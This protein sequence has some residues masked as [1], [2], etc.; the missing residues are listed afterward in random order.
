MVV[1]DDAAAHALARQW[2]TKEGYVISEA[3]TCDAAWDQIQVHP[4]DVILLDILFENG[5]SGWEFLERLRGDHRTAGIPVVVVSIVAELK[6]GLALGALEVLQKPVSG[7]ELLRAVASLGLSAGAE[8][9]SLLVVDDDPRAVEHVSKRLEQTGMYIT[10]AYGGEEALAALSAGSFGAMILDLMMPDVSGFEVVR[11]VRAN[12]ATAQLPIIVLTA[13]VLDPSERTALEKSV[14]AVLSKGDWDDREFLRVVRAAVNQRQR[15][16][17]PTPGPEHSAPLR[18]PTPKPD[19]TLHVLVIDDDAAAR[20]LLKLYLEDSGFVVTAAAGAKDALAAL[21]G[22][23][24]DLITLD[25][26]FEG[27]GDLFLSEGGGAEHL[28]GIPV[29]VVSS[30]DGPET[31]IGL[32]ARA[33]LRKPIRRHEFLEVVREVL[34]GVEQPRPYVI[35]ADDDPNAVKI[36]SSYFSDEAVDIGCAYGGREALALVA[37]RR[38]DVLI[39]DLMMPDVSGFDVLAQLRGSAATADLPVV[40]LS[41]MELTAAERASLAKDVQAV[42]AKAATSRGDLVEQ[43]RKVVPTAGAKR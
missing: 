17:R 19:P 1:D 14:N 32:Q 11:E 21:A 38:P 15:Q 5:P 40:I 36:I 25:P 24:P 23:R 43:V 20:E 22:A 2:L 31:A 13:K 8:P 6:R 39:L 3:T 35:V 12:P 29:L 37:E 30:A 34:S 42:L 27:M 7:P 28:R 26:L 16:L 41:A 4:P 10:R 18:A 33:V 9:V